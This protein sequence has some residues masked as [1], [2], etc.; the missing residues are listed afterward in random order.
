MSLLDVF[1]RNDERIQELRRLVE[2]AREEELRISR[3]E[4]AKNML[5]KM[6]SGY[7]DLAESGPRSR[8][9]VVG[10]PEPKILSKISFDDLQSAISR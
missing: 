3:E 7:P 2:L 8:A 6:F 9:A 1:R 10:E 4:A 5:G